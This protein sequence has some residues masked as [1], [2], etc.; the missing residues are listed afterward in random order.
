MTWSI[1][2]FSLSL[3]PSFPHFCPSASTTSTCAMLSRN[4]ESLRK[5]IVCP[6]LH[7]HFVHLLSQTGSYQELDSTSSLCRTN[8]EIL[9]GCESC[10]LAS[11]HKGTKGEIPTWINCQTWSG[12]AP[13]STAAG[14]SKGSDVF[15]AQYRAQLCSCCCSSLTW[16]HAWK[17]KFLSRQ[18]LASED[19]HSLLQKTLLHLA[20]WT[21]SLRSNQYWLVGRPPA[22]N[23]SWF[24]NDC[25]WTYRSSWTRTD[26]T[27]TCRKFSHLLLVAY[28]A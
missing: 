7:Y 14:P 27:Q 24:R 21:A 12:Q 22:N 20:L 3:L 9:R 5:I 4:S 8:A 10:W 19:E 13:V 11:A 28:N 2:S 17:Q 6:P 25:F 18:A 1:P 15:S 23:H 26:H 16:K